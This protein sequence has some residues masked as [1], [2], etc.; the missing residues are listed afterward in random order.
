[1]FLSR[2]AVKHVLMPL[3]VAVS[4]IYITSNCT[5]SF[6]SSV[7]AAATATGG[8]ASTHNFRC[9]HPLMPLIVPSHMHHIP[10]TS[11]ASRRS[12]ATGNQQ[13][14]IVCCSRLARLWAWEMRPHLCV[15][16]CVCRA[17]QDDDV[18]EPPADQTDL[19]DGLRACFDFLNYNSFVGMR[20]YLF[21]C[22]S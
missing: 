14:L 21:I 3:T 10:T 12:P 11:A 18:G 4:I 8:A 5:L 1:M 6:P 19:K 13:F 22:I 20:A 15:R 17:Q 2:R 7:A 9:I 16:V